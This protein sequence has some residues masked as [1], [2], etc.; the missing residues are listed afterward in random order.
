MI[1]KTAHFC[2]LCQSHQII[3]QIGANNANWH[4]NRVNKKRPVTAGLFLLDIISC[5]G[6]ALRHK[7]WHAI[8]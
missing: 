5:N 7:R 3:T 2:L 4:F 6:V 8:A 1:L